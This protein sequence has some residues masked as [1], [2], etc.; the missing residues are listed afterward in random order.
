MA[1]VAEHAGGGLAHRR[2]DR[3][4][5]GCA[6][7]ASPATASFGALRGASPAA[8]PG[9]RGSQI[10]TVVPSPT[11]L[12][13]RDRAARL[14]RE[15]VDHGQ[16]EPGA[17]A[18]VLGGEEGLGDLRQHVGGNAAAAVGDGEHDIVARPAGRADCRRRPRALSRGDGDRAALRHRVA[19]VDD[20]VHQREL[21]LGAVGVGAPDAVARSASRAATSPPSVWREQ[22]GDGGRQL[23]RCRS[24][25]AAASGGGRRRA[26]GRPAP[27]P[28]SAAWRVMPRILLLLVV[29]L[30]PPLDQAEA[31][32]HGGEQIVEIVGDAAGQLADRV[33]LARLEQLLFEH[34]ALGH[35]EQGAGIFGGRPSTS[36]AAA[37]PGRGNA[38]SWPS[39]Q[40]QRYSTAIAPARV[41][42]VQRR[43]R[44]LAVLGMEPVRPQRRRRPATASN[45]KPVNAVEI[46]ADELRARAAIALALLEIEH[47][48]QRVDDRRLAL[49]G[50]AELPLDLAAARHWRADWRRAI[51]AP[52]PPCAGSRGS[53][54]T[55]RRTPPT[56]ERSTTGSTGLNT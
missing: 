18:D 51:A 8:A 36:P 14:A 9:A 55:G 50:E 15:A 24:R 16:A 23:G 30:Q 37:R 20:Q 31:A 7:A 29:Q 45:G 6:A 19:R 41:A 38:C 53:S 17:L 11:L 26:A 22:L 1:H 5:A 21:E 47:D 40:R 52:A 44:A 4:P 49:L 46:A 54:R 32:E 3:R 10:S 56:L 28:C 33:H 2:R 42:L 27:T 43:Q 35:V 34:L 25:P 12:S 39:A 13:M 48:R